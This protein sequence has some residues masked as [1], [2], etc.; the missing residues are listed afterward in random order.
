MA[1]YIKI[2]KSLSSAAFEEINTVTQKLAY[3][4]KNFEFF[5]LSGWLLLLWL[6][7]ATTSYARIYTNSLFFVIFLFFTL[8]RMGNAEG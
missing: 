7:P 8:S 6:S 2:F 3:Y 5:R 1:Y 4:I